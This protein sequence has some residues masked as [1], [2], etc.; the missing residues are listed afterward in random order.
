MQY[1]IILTGKF[2]YEYEFKYL[3]LGISGGI[4]VKIGQNL[5]GAQKKNL[6]GAIFPSGTDIH[7]HFR[8][9]GETDKE[10]F[11]T[12]SVSALF[13][14]TTTVY[15]MPNNKTPILDYSSFGDK[16]NLVKRKSYCDFGL[17]S[18]FNGK[19][20]S[21]IDKRSSAIKIFLGGSTNSVPMADVPDKTIRGINELDVPVIFHGEDA[22]CLQSNAKAEVFNLREHNL[23]RPEECELSSAKRISELKLNHSVMAHIST[24]DSISH[25][26]EDVGREV[27]PHHLLLNDESE[28]SSWGKVNPPLREKS[29]QNRNLQAYLDGKFNLLSS[30]HAPHTER[31]K[32]EFYQAQSGI[33]GVETRIPLMLALIQNKVLDTRILYDTAIKNPSELMGIKKGKIQIGYYADFFSVRFSS[34]KRLNQEKL[35]SKVPISPFHGFP[36]IFPENVT[37]HGECV[38]ED[39]ELIEDRFGSHVGDLKA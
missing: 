24:P 21:I 33:I 25:L 17:Y 37:M 7:V 22:E 5:T 10:D 14:G 38:I 23:S 6:E 4:I 1:D 2:Y 9:P 16:L 26:S 20:L 27:T 11:S 8:D 15:D 34:I 13:G 29:T 30:D 32:E 18:M 39:S 35:H 3:E 12:G 31:E 19:N 36:V 28:A